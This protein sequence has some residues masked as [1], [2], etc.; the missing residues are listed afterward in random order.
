M[1]SINGRLPEHVTRS[2]SRSQVEV[3]SATRTGGGHLKLVTT[4]G[5][6]DRG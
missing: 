5:P 4:G 1:K 6:N 3:L 2:I